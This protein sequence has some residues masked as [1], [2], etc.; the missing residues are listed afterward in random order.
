MGRCWS[1]GLGSLCLGSLVR[2]LVRRSVGFGQFGLWL[3]SVYGSVLPSG[4]REISEMD[5]QFYLLAEGSMSNGDVPE[6]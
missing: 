4:G 1:F 5:I 2:S 3:L 6:S